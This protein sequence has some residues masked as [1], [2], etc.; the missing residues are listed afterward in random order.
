MLTV[1][2]TGKRYRGGKL[3]RVKRFGF[4]ESSVHGKFQTLFTLKV[5]D[6]EKTVDVDIT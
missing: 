2:P 4:P 3:S 5:Y 1:V 6:R